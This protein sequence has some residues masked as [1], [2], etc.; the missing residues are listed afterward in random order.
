MPTAIISDL[1][2]GTTSGADVA[3]RADVA[4][5]LFNALAPADRVIVLGDLLELRE[6]PAAEVLEL[7]R[8]FLGG[9]GEATAGKQVVIVPGNH[10]HE[11]VAPA[12]DAARLQGDP[13]PAVDA[14]FSAAT[15]ELSRRVAELM[16]HSEVVLAYPGIH[17]RGDVYATHGHY[18][19]THLTVPR[20]ECIVAGA[21]ARIAGERGDRE[22]VDPAAYE[23]I[24]TPL[25][26]FAHAIVQTSPS[27]AVTRGGSLSRAVWRQSNPSTRRSIRG[28]A[29]GGVAIPAAVGAINW[30][31][32]GPFRADISAVELRRA[33]LRAMADVV[34]SL[35]IEARHVIF[36]HT[37]RAG[38]LPGEVEGWWLR[39]GTR[40]TNTGSW[41]YE[42]AFAPKQDGRNPYWPGHVVYVRD[43][44]PPELVGLLSDLDFPE[45][46]AAIG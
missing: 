6:R 24:L 4:Q 46:R 19:D 2:L 37:H 15:G 34:A 36:G 10:D 41:L 16:P 31:G 14:T 7:T 1:H 30:A 29:L 27:R 39:G 23:A 5:R 43:E 33:G 42:P 11:L 32:I 18:L 12:L 35:G 40:L 38:P 28:W 3:R 44:G 22:L 45:I 20:V 9:L 13:K 17:L 26:A 8:Q 25:Y 21:I